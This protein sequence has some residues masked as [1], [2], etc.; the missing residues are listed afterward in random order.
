MLT[1]WKIGLYD[2]YGNGVNS[3]S[4]DGSVTD[5]FLKH[6][7]D[8]TLT[9]PLN[10]IDELEFSLLLDDPA[11]SLI[12]RKQSF[13]RVWRNINDTE[14]SKTRTPPSETPDF[15]GMVTG[16]TKSGEQNMMRVTVMG[17]LWLIQTHFHLLNHRLVV[18]PTSANVPSYRQGSN[19]TGLQ[20]DHSALMFHLIDLINGAFRFS[21]GD[22]GIVKPLTADYTGT[23][24]MAGMDLFWPQT[25]ATSPLYV[26]AGQYTWPIFMELLGRDGSPD[27]VPE[28]ILDPGNIPRMFFKTAIVR[29][30]DKT[31]TVSFDYDTGS[32]SLTDCEEQSQVVPGEFGNFLWVSGD[33]GPNNILVQSSDAGDISDNGVFMVHENIPGSKK[34]DVQQYADGKKKVLLQADSEIYSVSISP[35]SP[36]YYDLDYTL[37]DLVNFNAAKGALQATNKHQRIYQVTLHWSDNN[38]ESTEIMISNDFKRKFP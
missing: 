21:G 12:T 8:C 15:C 32:K 24:Y 29:G 37:G 13:V 6:A 30:S 10:G 5:E 11:A 3:T 14:N 36:L 22:T 38:V 25:I 33:G 9:Y 31:E 23:G 19:E 27:I 26:M 7:T 18:D 1:E 28:Y 34:A 35:A 4:F 16:I 20:W 17:T 2:P